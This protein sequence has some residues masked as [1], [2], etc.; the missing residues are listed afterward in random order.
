M[1][2]KFKKYNVG[3][4]IQAGLGAAQTVYGISQLPRARAE[5]E[6]ARAAA[7]SLETPSQYYENYKNAYDSEL[8]RM[9]DDMIQ[10]NLATSVQALQGAGGRALV[11]GLSAATAQSQAA[12]MQMLA[13]ERAARMQAGQQLAAAQ[14]REVGRREARSQ[15]NIQMANQGYQAAL[16]NIGAGLGAIGT[17]LMYGL[18]DLSIKDMIEGR[19]ARKEYMN[20]P[21][22]NAFKPKDGV[23]QLGLDKSI[24]AATKSANADLK[25]IAD[26]FVQAR[27]NEAAMGLERAQTDFL[28]ENRE[29]N[30]AREAAAKAKAQ[31]EARAAAEAERRKN[32]IGP[33]YSM[34]ED[35]LNNVQYVGAADQV[36]IPNL[37][38]PEG[39][40]YSYVGGNVYLQDDSKLRSFEKGVA[41]QADIF[42][43]RYIDSSPLPMVRGIGQVYDAVDN[44]LDN[45]SRIEQER[46]AARRRNGSFKTGG[47]MTAGEFNHSTNPIDIVQNGIK[48]G[49][50]TG[51][52]YII[53]PE[54]AAKIAQ[55]SSFARKLF[56]RFEKNAKKNK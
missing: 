2:A 28:K 48:V 33:N 25:G 26:N 32:L 42:R 19:A 8:A 43:A 35:R 15:Q 38:A 10:R 6:R 51:E 56:K 40:S 12:Q 7:P 5:F 3:G 30:A 13:G 14:E 18:E 46:Q 50:A 55:Q 16:G 9:Q 4:I 31:A 27:T 53:N 24:E 1:K 23:A 39:K 29:F 11:G 44:W 47:M 20:T 22:A 41:N 37:K 17:G 49:E 54:Q 34:F 52:E 21:I 36:D 45:A